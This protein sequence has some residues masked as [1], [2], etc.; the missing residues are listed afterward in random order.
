MWHFS[1]FPALLE[2]SDKC[3]DWKAMSRSFAECIRKHTYQIFSQYTV[4][5]HHTPGNLDRNLLASSTG[6]SQQR[7]QASSSQNTI[8]ESVWGTG[9]LSATSP[10]NSHPLSLLYQHWSYLLEKWPLSTLLNT[11]GPTVTVICLKLC[12][13]LS[14]IPQGPVVSLEGGVFNY[15]LSGHSLMA[16]W[17]AQWC[18]CTLSPVPIFHFF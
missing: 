11:T 9:A 7:A 6:F 12:P 3:S 17:V 5:W 8:C 10:L 16:H 14:L 13:P 18:L 4:Y 2:I 1:T 15:F